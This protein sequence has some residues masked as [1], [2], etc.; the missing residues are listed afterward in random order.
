M[1]KEYYNFIK[2][3]LKLAALKIKYKY[4]ISIFL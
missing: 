1:I 4:I 2:D 3:Y